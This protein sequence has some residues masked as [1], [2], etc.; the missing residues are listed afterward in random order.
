[1]EKGALENSA[2]VLEELAVG[3]PLAVTFGCTRFALMMLSPLVR[4][5]LPD[6]GVRV[7]VATTDAPRRL[8]AYSVT[9]APEDSNSTM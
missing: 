7:D 6:P 1:M 9:Y 3:M 8:S 4:N 5:V 2:S